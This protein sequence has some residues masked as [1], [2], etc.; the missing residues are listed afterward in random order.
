LSL[1]RY[2]SGPL[3]VCGALS[4]FFRSLIVE[5]NLIAFNLPNWITIVLMAAAGYLLLG[6]LAQLVIAQF[7]SSTSTATPTSTGGY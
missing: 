3:Q 2:N 1:C 7:G 4:N 5:R 6:I